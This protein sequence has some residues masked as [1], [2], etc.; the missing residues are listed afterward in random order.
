METLMRV[1]CLVSLQHELLHFALLLWRERRKRLRPDFLFVDLLID[2]LILKADRGFELKAFE[3]P[4]R[5]LLYQSGS[6]RCT[7]SQYGAPFFSV[8]PSAISF[9]RKDIRLAKYQTEAGQ[10]VAL[11]RVNLSGR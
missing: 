8:T 11:D 2:R 5:L 4:R 3:S 7:E 9:P 10:C 1:R 6:F